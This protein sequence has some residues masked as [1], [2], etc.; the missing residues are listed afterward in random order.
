MGEVWKARDTRVDR[1]VAIKSSQEQF[2][3]RFEREARAIAALN[4]PNICSLFDIGPDYLVMECIDGVPIKPV[5]N[6]RKLLD[7]AV[8]IADGLSAAHA[9]GIIHRDLK[10]ANVLVTRDGRVKILDFGLAKH[11]GTA[12]ADEDATQTAGATNPGTVLG[13]VSYMSPEQAGGLPLD[14]RS[15][16]FSFGVMLYELASGN[17][18]FQR[19]TAAQTMAAIIEADP[20]PLP[21][22]VP[23][24]LRWIIERCLAKEA[25]ARFESTRDLYRDLRSLR[26]H[27]S[28]ILSPGWAPVVA[29]EPSTWRWIWPTAAVAAIVLAVLTAVFGYSIGTRRGAPS[30]DL[31]PIPIT[32]SGGIARNPSFSPDASQVVFAWNGARQGNFNLYVRLIGSNDLLRL[33]NDSAN[34]GSPTWSPDGKRI[35]FVRNLGNRKCSVVMTSPLG[36]S[37]RKLTDIA[38]IDVSPEGHSLLAWTPDGRYL[39]VPDLRA[40]DT[41]GPKFDL[42]SI[43]TAERRPLTAKAAG[44]GAGNGDMDPA[45]SPAGDRFAFVRVAGAFE[46]RAMWTRLGK[47]YEPIGPVTEIHTSALINFSAAWINNGELLLS[48]G[49][50]QAMRLHKVALSSSSPAVPVPAILTTGGIALSPKTGRLIYPS[51]QRFVNLYRLP[52]NTVDRVSGH[53][54]RLTSTTGEDFLPRYSRDGKSIAFGSSRFG[55]FGIWTVPIGEQLGAALTTSLDATLALG[56]WA[57]D[58]K[59]LVYFRT[60]PPGG[61]W[62]LYRVATDTG[63]TTR[64]T[65]DTTDDFFPNYSRDGNSIYFSSSRSGKVELYKM[66]ASGGPATL[67]VPRSVTNAQ[68]SPDSRWLYFADWFSGNGLWRMSAAGGEITRVAERISDVPGYAATN[69]GVYYWAPRGLRH[70]LRFINLQSHED[71]LVFEPSTPVTP[72]LT[73][74]SDGRYICF[75]EIERNSQELMMIEGFR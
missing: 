5:Q 49:Q 13:T 29:A 12:L 14:A 44:Q 63:H 61:R 40:G 4:H 69:Q 39:A 54:E 53:P 50:P 75:P 62:Q 34:E 48:A 28:E 32:S 74:S 46:G 66:P 16:Q 72:Y 65:N 6:T 25:T 20:E 73:I 17:R 21:Q 59:S 52:L 30:K 2:S 60:T 10:P 67:M 27:F 23:A 33:T 31:T 57:P 64:V 42:I 24:P 9:A 58:G 68:E 70:E 43:D 41:T 1:I 26:A 3:M 47:A 45:F 51:A 22:A 38:C 15:D 36:G 11:A 35:A 37:E 71:R 18:P 56:D 8:Q 55:E 19:E 7:L